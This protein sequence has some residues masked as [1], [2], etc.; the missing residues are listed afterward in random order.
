MNVLV[1][2]SD[3]HSFRCLGTGGHP[4]IQTPN[5][6]ALAARGTRFD[7]AWAASPICVPTRASL[8]TGR[9]VHQLATWDSAQPYTGNVRGWAHVAR[10][11]GAHSV[12]I[13]KLHFRSSDDDFGFTESLLPMHVID[14]RGWVQG[15]MRNP[16]PPYPEAAELGA[17]AGVGSSSYTEYDQRITDRTIEWL[18]EHAAEDRPFAAFVSLV[19]PHYPLTVDEEYFAPYGDLANDTPGIALDISPQAITHPAVEAMADFFSYHKTMDTVTADLARRAYFGL[20]TWLDHN[21][22]RILGALDDAGATDDTLVIY[23]SDH[24]DLHGNRGLWGKSFMYEDSVRVPMIIAGPG[25]PAGRVVDTPVNQIDIH[26]T[27]C[28]VMDPN[29]NDDGPGTSLLELLDRETGRVGFSEYHDGGSITA[30][31]AVQ[32]RMWKY[33]HH[34]G[35]DPELYDLEADPDELIDL[36]TSDDHSAVRRECLHALHS[37]V[38]PNAVNA[39]A[40]ASQAALIDELGGAGALNDHRRFNH[41]PTPQ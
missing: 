10:D 5:L 36:G 6:D 38:D 25:V 29:H 19:A 4:V 26:P 18:S 23:T 40:F 35:Y 37:I 27:V 20:C 9:W 34:V 17:E 39:A 7:R 41:T 13:G 8:A 14:G 21:V 30:S 16:L 15:L 2:C 3:E 24:G 12:S 31:F 33:I 32:V 1:I 22:G 28:A 11:A